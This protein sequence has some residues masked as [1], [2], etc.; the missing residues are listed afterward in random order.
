MWDI[1]QQQLIGI[2]QNKYLYCR[3]KNSFVKGIKVEHSAKTLLNFSGT[4][5]P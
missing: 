4:S 5:A 1:L 3:L 2:N